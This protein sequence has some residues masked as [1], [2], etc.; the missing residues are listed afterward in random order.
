MHDIEA[1]PTI[2]QIDLNVRVNGNQ[3]YAGFENIIQ[4]SLPSP[5]LGYQFVT[6]TEIESGLT[7]PGIVTEMDYDKKII[8]LDVDWK[9]L[10]IQEE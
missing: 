8:Y 10:S 4:G 6:V 1:I 7:G 2:I 5:Y 9:Q 3:T